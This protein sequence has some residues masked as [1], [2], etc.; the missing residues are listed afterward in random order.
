MKITCLRIHAVPW[1]HFTG[2]KHQRAL[3]NRGLGHRG[4]GRGRGFPRVP[5]GGGGGP[6]YG[7]FMP[8]PGPG[9]YSP[10]GFDSYACYDGYVYGPAPT[11]ASRFSAPSN[12]TPTPRSEPA[13]TSSTGP[14]KEQPSPSGEAPPELPDEV[15]LVQEAGRDTKYKCKACNCVLHSKNALQQVRT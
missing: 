11:Y 10:Y 6:G 5:R 7:H 4:G 2:S 15:V 1:S 9:P 14:Q 12:Q 3:E 8:Y 13:S